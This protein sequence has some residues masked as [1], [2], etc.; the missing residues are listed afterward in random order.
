MGRKSRTKGH[1]FEREVARLFRTIWP[2]AKRGY[3]SRDGGKAAADVEGTPWHI[4]CKRYRKITSRIIRDAFDQVR[5][6]GDSRPPLVVVKED[7]STIFVY[8]DPQVSYTVTDF[9]CDSY[10]GHLG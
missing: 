4:E 2:D 3:Q 9:L 7:R 5:D 1:S 6:S 8:T 10:M